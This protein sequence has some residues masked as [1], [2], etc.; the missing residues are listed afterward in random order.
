M[1]TANDPW[2]RVDADG[3]VYVRTADGERVIG[4]WAAGSPE[5]ALAFFRRKFASLETEVALI[6]QRI[7]ATEIAPA[8]AQSTVQR[9][10]R[11]VADANASVTWTG[12]GRAWRRWR[13]RST[14]AARRSRPPASTRGWRPARSRSGSSRRPSTSRPRRRTGRPAASG[15][16]SCSRSGR[17]RRTPTGR[18]RRCCG[19]G[20]PRRATP[21][22]S[23]ARPTSPP[24][25]PSGRPS[26]SARR[27][28]W[29]RP[30]RWRTRPTGGPPRR[31]T[32][33]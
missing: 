19:S 10:L 5:E 20:C 21:S 6:E 29:R 15:W 30:S 26:G 14:T 27:S 25:R 4:S 33:S 7:A 23:G 3:T 2:G 28:W 1:T 12:S 8:Q 32:A 24:W 31:R 22:P 11:A 17:P 13:P 16:P 18:S 9:L